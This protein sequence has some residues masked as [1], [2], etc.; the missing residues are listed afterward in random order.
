MSDHINS[1]AVKIIE[2]IGISPKSFDDAISQA[3]EKASKTVKGITGI[4]V[5]KQMASVENGKIKQYNVDLKVAF[6]V[7]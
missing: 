7:N 4:E 3:L 5:I 2:I 6:A 1:G